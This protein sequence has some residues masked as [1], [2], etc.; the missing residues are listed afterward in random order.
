MSGLLLIILLIVFITILAQGQSF[1]YVGINL[2][3]SC[4]SHGQFYVACSR[5]TSALH[6]HIYSPRAKTEN[7]VYTEIL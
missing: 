4:F 7:I 3:E 5:A 2:I 6:L 1:N